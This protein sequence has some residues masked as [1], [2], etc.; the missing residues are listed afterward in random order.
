M[1]LLHETLVA[2]LAVIGIN[3]FISGIFYLFNRTKIIY[4]HYL[5]FWS[6]A[7]LSF[8]GQG[9]VQ[10][11]PQF[12]PLAFS[13]TALS[14]YSLCRLI[15]LITGVD[16][17]VSVRKFLGSIF[18]SILVC[19]AIS[20]YTPFWLFSLPIIVAILFPLIR[21][22]I[23]CGKQFYQLTLSARMF[24]FVNLILIFHQLDF[25]FLRTNEDFAP[26]GFIIATIYSLIFGMIAPIAISEKIEREQ[27]EITVRL[28]EAY[29]RFFPF[30]Y[31]SIMDKSIFDVGEGSHNKHDNAAILFSDLRD[32]TQFSEDR[33][34]VDVY[35]YIEEYFNTL[36][37]KLPDSTGIVDKFSG[38]EVMI[39]YHDA[40][41]QALFDAD[42]L[43]NT[44]GFNTGVGIGFGDIAVGV[45]GLNRNLN[46]SVFGSK[47]NQASRLCNM[48]KA[49]GAK[50][51]VSEEYYIKIQE[52][53]D[54]RLNDYKFRWCGRLQLRGK[55]NL[56]SIYECYSVLSKERIESI[57]KSKNVMQIALEKYDDGDLSGALDCL[58]KVDECGDD[59]LSNFIRRKILEKLAS[60][61]NKAI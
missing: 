58:D 36:L 55:K 16:S 23:S 34:S 42:H 33:D 39:V 60:Q 50:I 17:S 57:E 12:M 3:I 54:P 21:V 35:R 18:L 20:G 27:I 38:D 8:L 9:L 6:G 61:S 25:P 46:I 32:F 45:I 26:I 2:N 28:K 43:V 40:P 31:L 7:L 14:N 13:V 5:V 53:Q 52:T 59:P 30:D 29:Q 4:T 56:C 41:I 51:I 24:L 49:L 44:E 10:N 19:L 1:T 11:H 22:V 37:K 47:V 15:E 48:V